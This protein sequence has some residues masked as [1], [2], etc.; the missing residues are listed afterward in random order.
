MSST[1]V[2]IRTRRAFTLIELLVVIAIIAILASMLLPA[3]SKARERAKSISCAS[4]LKQMGL[5]HNFYAMANDDF[6]VPI[7]IN[8]SF[9]WWTVLE[10][11]ARGVTYGSING[12]AQTR[13]TATLLYCPTMV[14]MGFNARNTTASKQ[15]TTYIG[16]YDLQVTVPGT[17][18][19]IR[20]T[21][22]HNTSRSLIN[23]DACGRPS[24]A[25]PQN[26]ALAVQHPVNVTP[27]AN[28][29][30]LGFVHNGG[31]YLATNNYA[32]NCNILFV[33]GHVNSV[34]ARERNER[35]MTPIAYKDFV[36]INNAVMWE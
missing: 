5:A 12:V 28:S 14:G 22:L 9:N 25:H 18:P 8:N 10:A 34:G 7:K 27:H 4:N 17:T 6:F 31:N 1:S 29:G 20:V 3:L 36:N 2:C 35:N 19:G 24:D 15:D 23:A 21:Q 11:E 13:K 26:R 16:N 32:G 30:Q 33:D